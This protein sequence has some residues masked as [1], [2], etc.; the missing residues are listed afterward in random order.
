MAVNHPQTESLTFLAT[1]GG[2]PNFH[3]AILK[4]YRLRIEYRLYNLCIFAHL[5]I[6]HVQIWFYWHPLGLN[7][8]ENPAFRPPNHQNESWPA[9]NL[10][11]AVRMVVANAVASLC[12]ISTSARQ[13]FLKLDEANGES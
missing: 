13:N 11:I 1:R 12:E 4:D 3:D 8:M 6:T 7:D 10:H 2:W 9:R 5:H